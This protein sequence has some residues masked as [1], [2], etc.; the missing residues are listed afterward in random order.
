[1]V[2][3]ALAYVALFGT[4]SHF[5]NKNF[6][7]APPEPATLRLAEALLELHLDPEISD[8][9]LAKSLQAVM[10]RAASGEI[11]A[12]T[13]VAE[14]ASL[15]RGVPGEAVACRL[16]CAVDVEDLTL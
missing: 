13:F 11:E 7:T 12:A 9:V 16:G 1:M 2:L 10:N 15:Q 14:L 8:E 3:A 6:A 4:G 5:G